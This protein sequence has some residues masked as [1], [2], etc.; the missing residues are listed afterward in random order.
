MPCKC[1][2]ILVTPSSVPPSCSEQEGRGAGSDGEEGSGD[3]GGSG[4]DG[5]G[6]GAERGGPRQRQRPHDAQ[7]AGAGAG[8]GAGGKA[9]KMSKH[10]LRVMAKTK[11]KLDG[12][13]GRGTQAGFAKNLA[14]KK[15]FKALKAKKK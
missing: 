2:T 3:E 10:A 12:K 13:K 5:G 8:G 1:R 6:G 7:Q 15:K 14:S 4:S 11:M 9:Y